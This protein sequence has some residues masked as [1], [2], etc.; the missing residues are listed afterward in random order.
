MGTDDGE[1]TWVTVR[2]A[3]ARHGV[4][5]RCVLKWVQSGKVEARRHGRRWSVLCP[6][7][8]G[9]PE[10]EVGSGQPDPEKR[11]SSKNKDFPPPPRRSTGQKSARDDA[12]RYNVQSLSA[13]QACSVVLAAP[14][15]H[16]GDDHPLQRRLAGNAV[17]VFEEL[18]RGYHAYHY[19][20]KVEHYR[21]AR[22][23]L[24]SVAA[25]AE[26]LGDPALSLAVQESPLSAVTALI[27]AMERKKKGGRGA[28]DRD[29]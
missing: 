26:L 18:A 16:L 4:T 3:A 19:R 24:C 6:V 29:G 23:A 20:D 13:W 22:S 9:S 11:K 12:G 2:E 7:E 15:E 17:R 25:I 8:N 5:E 27:R 28:A 10:I 21:E 1:A 14:L